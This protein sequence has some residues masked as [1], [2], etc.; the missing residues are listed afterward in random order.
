MIKKQE[1][2]ILKENR[3]LFK[4]SVLNGELRRALREGTIARCTLEEINSS[5][6]FFVNN[7]GEPI[8]PYS[9]TVLTTNNLHLEHI[10]PISLGGGTVSENL[11]PCCYQCNCSKNGH[12]MIEWYETQSFF[13]IERFQKIVDYMFYSLISKNVLLTDEYDI[14]ELDDHDPIIET[15]GNLWE[16]QEETAEQYLNQKKNKLKFDEFLVQC[17][18]KLNENGIFYNSQGKNYTELFHELI[19]K[20]IINVSQDEINIQQTIFNEIKNI[21]KNKY[22]TT[23]NIDYKKIKDNITIQQQDISSYLKHRFQYLKDKLSIN[24]N[25]LGLLIENIPNI[26][27]YSEKELNQVFSIL[28]SKININNMYAFLIN[29]NLLFKN[30]IDLILKI[31]DENCEK[32]KENKYLYLNGIIT[33][34]TIEELQ[35][36]FKNGDI[37]YFNNKAYNSRLLNVIIGNSSIRN[38]LI[39]REG[40]S[41]FIEELILTNDYD[42]F[43]RK[44]KKQF[45]E[46]V[47][48]LEFEFKY[49]KIINHPDFKKYLFL[50]RFERNE[51]KNN[52]LRIFENQKKQILNCNDIKE[53]N[54]KEHTYKSQIQTIFSTNSTFGTSGKDN[55]YIKLSEFNQITELLI[56][57]EKINSE[58]I[59]S[60]LKELFLKKGYTEDEFNIKY[61]RYISNEKITYLI[62]LEK[63]KRQKIKKIYENQLKL[64][65]DKINNIE[66]KNEFKTT[67]FNF[68]NKLQLLLSRNTCI[69]ERRINPS[70]FNKIIDDL[71]GGLQFG[72][73]EFRNELYKIFTNNGY[74]LE[75]FEEKYCNIVNHNEIFN[76][77]E[78]M[79]AKTKRIAEINERFIQEEVIK[80]NR[81]KTIQELSK[82]EFWFLEKLRSIFVSNSNLNGQ[83]LAN[84]DFT[85]LIE[86]LVNGKKIED[87]EIR[88]KFYNIFKNICNEDKSLI[89]QKYTQYLINDDI[90]IYI[91]LERVKRERVKEIYQEKY[92][93]YKAIIE[94][95]KSKEELLSGTQYFKS[96]IQ[97]ILSN[98][99]RANNKM[100][101]LSAFKEIS[102]KLI[103]GFDIKTPEIKSEMYNIFAINGYTEDEFQ[104]KYKL[105]CSHPDLYINIELERLKRKKLNEFNNSLGGKKR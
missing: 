87:E 83:K 29:N 79:K 77:I 28:E 74:S 57:G 104:N 8:C 50:E 37:K 31:I 32:L 10:I 45:N 25:E 35:E 56:N 47:T 73:V 49:F 3:L 15:S 12:H 24:E 65:I 100:I 102:E 20:K 66:D 58:K 78:L 42:T 26:I 48:D 39:N 11:I 54:G 46:S 94:N 52:N 80:I 86:E 89:E 34:N 6:T 75:E 9:G 63:I 22:T 4:K 38:K 82:K 72:S 59:K 81:T 98:N 13:T 67:E 44:L 43:K 5:L 53:L 61:L 19:E 23:L 99:S 84:S 60:M 1:Q 55:R 62:E 96:N 33:E 18:S 91:V 14:D 7:K 105:I 64:A 17:I 95:A 97:T 68:K 36:Y 41:E 70:Y 30:Q 76:N 85:E 103:L 27:S 69:G 92:N 40:L 93:Y 21:V 51:I 2:G 71:N 16:T 90:N 88:Q 101:G